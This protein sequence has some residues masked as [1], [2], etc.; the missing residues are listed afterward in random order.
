MP[1]GKTTKEAISELL[2][3]KADGSLYHREAKDLEFKESFNLAGMAEYLRDFAAFSNHEGGYLV[4]GITNSPRKLKGLGEK[5]KAQFLSIDEEKISGFIAEYFSPYFDWESGSYE[6]KGKFFGVFY[7]HKSPQKPV[8]CKKDAGDI[9]KNG[10]IYYRYAGRTQN[11][12]FSELSGIIENRIKENNEAWI[13]KVRSIGEAGPENVGILDTQKG[14]LQAGK[15]SLL[16]DEDLIKK[17][18]FIKEG[19]F[20]EKRGA[21]TLKLIGEVKGIEKVEVERIL[22]KRLIDEYPF[23]YKKLVSEVKKEAPGAKIAQIQKIVKENNV[24][25]D[26]NYSAFN[27]RNKDQEN[28]YTKSGFVP[29]SIA[30]IYNQRAVDL[31]SKIV[32]NETKN[33][34][35]L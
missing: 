6:D 8:I 5:A 14:I 31:I 7:I 32:Q 33:E 19:E 9:L 23:S 22:K 4:F 12:G 3:L 25:K 34:S 16:L 2:K 21:T 26:T 20:S 28:E 17:I 18:K 35:I 11:I 29:G 27:F 24:K 10:A 15:T 30:S 13:Q 1:E